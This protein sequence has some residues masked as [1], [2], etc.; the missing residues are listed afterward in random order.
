VGREVFYVKSKYIK[1]TYER[2]IDYFIAY[3]TLKTF[4]LDKVSILLGQLEMIN[5][6]IL[7]E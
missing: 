1:V 5:R 7:L 2:Y 4:F 6:S 3:N